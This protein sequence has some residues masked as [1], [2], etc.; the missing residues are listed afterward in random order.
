MVAMLSKS[1]LFRS[2]HSA[3]LFS[4]IYKLSPAAQ[5]FGRSGSTVLPAA[6]DDAAYHRNTCGSY[7]LF[8]NH[9][10]EQHLWQRV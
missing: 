8:T 3:L 6:G 1:M 7:E 10:S 4:Y 9:Y 2:I 5:P